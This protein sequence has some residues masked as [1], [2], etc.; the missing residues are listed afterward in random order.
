MQN[1]NPS[2]NVNR[3]GRFYIVMGLLVGLSGLIAV[4]LGILFLALPLLGTDFSS[5]VGLCLNAVGI[6]AALGGAA[7]MVRGFTLQKDNP[8]AYEV[9]ETLK[10]TAIGDDPRY[11]FIRNINRRGLGYIDAVLVGPP[12]VLVFRTVDY[13]GGWINERAEWRNRT[14]SGN[15]RGAS[16]NPTRECARDVHAL[17][18]FLA[19][20]KLEKVPVYGII[21]FV[22]SPDQLDLRADAPVIP[23]AELHTLFYIMNQD[24]L[25]EERINSPTIRAT[26]DAVID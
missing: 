21:V 24:Y 1:I 2:K 17:R 6:L 3:R 15:L 23:I 12:G 11:T 19:K 13:Q 9:G 20:N 16:T 26:V 18:D 5:P 14:R 8:L 25:R 7:G 4:A 22:T 10:E